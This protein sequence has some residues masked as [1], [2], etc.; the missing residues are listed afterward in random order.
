QNCRIRLAGLA[1][2]DSE[3]SMCSACP[4]GCTFGTA[5]APC[6]GVSTGGIV[7]TDPNRSE[8]LSEKDR[9]VTRP[10]EPLATPE[11]S[12]GPQARGYPADPKP[13]PATGQGDPDDLGRSA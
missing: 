3:S 4:A 11:D 7:M 1:A 8:Q 5:I 10:D 2:G 6:C 13:V 9:L 12:S